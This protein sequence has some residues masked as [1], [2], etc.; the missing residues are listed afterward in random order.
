MALA[1][2]ALACNIWA[3]S[4]GVDEPLVHLAE[5]AVERLAGTR[6]T[7][8]LAC[9]KGL[10]AV[11]LYWSDQVERRERLGAEALAL[12][13]ADHGREHT[14]E[15]EHVL[16]YVLAR[17]LL[18]VWGPSSAV[19]HLPL[20]DE[21]LVLTRKL[22][23]V[24]LEILTRNWRVTVLLELG[25]FSAVDQEISRLQQIATDLR[26]PRAMVFLPLH[27]G[28]RAATN[29]H[30]AEAERLNAESIEIGRRVRGTVGELAATAQLLSIRLQQGRLVELEPAVR[31]LANANPG[32][33]AMQ[34]VLPLIMVESGRER[35]AAAELERLMASGIAGLPRDNVHI[36]T[37]AI[38][39]EVAAE[40]GDRARAGELYAWLEPY[41]GRWVVSAGAAALWPVE[42][43]LARLATVAGQFELAHTHIDRAGAQAAGSGASPSIALLGLDEARL[44]LA[45]GRAEDR[46]RIGALAREARELAQQLG[47]G[48]VVDHAT[49]LEAEAVD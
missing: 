27:H 20:S 40:L 25:R 5:E 19:E 21:L 8:V 24:E 17:Y 12:A 36:V 4:L 38:L 48:L 3:L 23:D 29:G 16:A 13:R 32:M 30:F 15:S 39:G 7:G 2:A 28:S 11:T 35:E 34:A 31:A 1:R 42:R 18:T 9:V 46:P 45:E 6:E 49:L 33:K 41:A 22:R 10:L 14:R 43:S 26:Q 44:L 37:L 47:M